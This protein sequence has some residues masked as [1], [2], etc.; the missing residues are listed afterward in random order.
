[1]KPD[2][3]HIRSTNSDNLKEIVV[4]INQNAVDVAG[5]AWNEQNFRYYSQRD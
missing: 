1:M 5:S 4:R 2:R 3:W